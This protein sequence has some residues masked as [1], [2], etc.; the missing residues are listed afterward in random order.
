MAVRN[1]TVGASIDVKKAGNPDF[2]GVSGL[3]RIAPDS[4]L[5]PG[6]IKLFPESLCWSGF[7]FSDFWIYPQ[8][9]PQKVKATP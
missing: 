8:M 3:L 1:D 9:Y 2:T 7:R 6:A 5:V 4:I